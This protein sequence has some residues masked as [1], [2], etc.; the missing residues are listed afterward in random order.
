MSPKQ[1][2]DELLRLGYDRYRFDG[3]PNPLAG[4]PKITCNLFLPDDV[5]PSISV[6]STYALDALRNALRL[7]QQQ[8]RR[9]PTRR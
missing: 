3:D 2:F 5:E 1:I 6:T 7:A 8:S 9:T 4:Q